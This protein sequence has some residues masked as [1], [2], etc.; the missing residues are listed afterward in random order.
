MR[1]N[2]F[3]FQKMGRKNLR[4]LEATTLTSKVTVKLKVTSK[5]GEL[6]ERESL[7]GDLSE[8]SGLLF[9]E[10]NLLYFLD[11][12]HLFNTA[13]SNFKFGEACW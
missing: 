4:S 3:D 10:L 5:W 12:S 8:I 11:F 9:E 2:R 7:L 1:T 13:K 6:I